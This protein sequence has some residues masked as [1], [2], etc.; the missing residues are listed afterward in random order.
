[1]KEVVV[2]YFRKNAGTEDVL[3]RLF[4]RPDYNYVVM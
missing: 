4:S 2:P 3:F 1:M